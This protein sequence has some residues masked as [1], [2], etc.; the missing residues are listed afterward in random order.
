MRPHRRQCLGSDHSFHRRNV[1]NLNVDGT[2]ESRDTVSSGA[3]K[4]EPVREN[5]GLSPVRSTPCLDFHSGPRMMEG[6]AMLC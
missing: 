3:I 1:Y 6:G 5:V 2:T 4:G